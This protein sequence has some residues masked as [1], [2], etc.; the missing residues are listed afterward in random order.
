M[1]LSFR[2]LPIRHKLITLTVG[3]SG[4]ALVLACTVFALF[5]QAGF[6]RTSARDIAI[7][8]D[9]FDDNVAAGVTFDD[10][11]AIA[12]TLQTLRANPHIVAACVYDRQGAVIGE[13]RRSGP[14]A[15][16]QF[17]FPVARPTSQQVTP[18]R[19][20]TF[21]DITLAGEV[22]GVV[23]IG[24]E[25]TELHAR[26]RRYVL[27]VG[28]LLIACSFV[29]WALARWL[30][31]IISQPILELAQ[32]V[33]TIATEKNY[34]VRAPKQGDDELGRLIDGFNEMLT[35]IQARDTALR[36]AGEK[37]E[38]RVEERTKELAVERARFKFIFD[39]VPVGITLVS[40]DFKVHLTNPATERI[41]GVAVADVAQPDAFVR[42]SHPDDYRRQMELAQPFIRGEIDHYSVEKRYVHPNGHIVWAL[43]TSRKFFASATR[44][45]QAVTTLVDIS[46]LKNAQALAAREQAR[47]KFIFDS[48]P[49]GISF[50]VNDGSNTHLVNPAHARI[51]GV[52]AESAG[53]AGVFQRA[54]HP[55]DY[56]RQMEAAQPFIRAEVD[57]YSVE[58]RYLHADGSVVWTA[59]T[60]RKFTDAATGVLQSITTLIDITE[61]KKAETQL[62]NSLSLLHATLESTADGILVVG[63]GG[64]LTTF[65]RTFAEMWCLPP[66]V[67]GRPDSGTALEVVLGQLKQPETFRQRVRDLTAQPETT[68]FDMLDLR[69]GRIF[70]SY[71]QPQR[72][73]PAVAGRVW[74]FRDVTERRKTEDTLRRQQTELRVLFDLVPAMIWFKDTENRILRVNRRVADNAGKS[75][76]EIEGKP[77][78]EIYPHEAAKFYADD[79]KVIRSG[80][81]E[82][83]IVEALHGTKDGEVWVQT[84]KVPVTDGEG[85]VIGIIVMA[86]D[87]TERKRSEA[88]LLKV[89]R[90]LV[91]ASRQAGM[92]EVATGVLH[93]VGN[94][95]NSVNVSA[96]L[97]SD[98]VRQTAAGKIA[99]LATLVQ[100]H[101][102]DLAAFLTT[103]PRGRLI[104]DYLGTLAAAL[105]TEHQATLDELDHL[106]KNI[107]HIKEIVA[108]QQSY[109]RASGIIETVVLAELVDDTLRMNTGSFAQHGIEAIRDYQARP[110]VS[111]D[112]HKVMQI[113]INLVRNAKYAC[114]DSGRPDKRITLHTRSDEQRFTIAVSDNG[115]GISRENLTRIFSHGFTTRPDGH[116]FGLHSGALAARELGGSLSVQS[117]GPGLG[118]T[119]TLELP[120][121]PE[122]PAHDHPAR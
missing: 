88:E 95:L 112:K 62:A 63:Q 57:H 107:D 45:E 121:Q 100:A 14:Q 103:D 116:G 81:S 89:H 10:S 85:R 92:A 46:E 66:E 48:V 56:R 68:S 114:D 36:T 97:I 54:S 77:S 37:L 31:R 18:D 15:D 80:V 23:Y 60:S 119:F 93:N 41:T 104:P 25:L 49:V 28:V 72:V 47:F 61:R 79:L 35:Q 115:V 38:G 108:V 52:S 16:P 118:A 91:A 13:Y 120:C 109:A 40:G 86:Q 117:D 71:S 70:E 76:E 9:M 32:T 83:G 22:I 82:L 29:A 53:V 21:Q 87:I 11:E 51:T 105:A 55:D 78:A 58:K 3:I 102:T 33:A 44:E 30:Q 65:N 90:E 19:L 99:K 113:L 12:R 64:R 106:R 110:T 8:A 27:F 2:N 43:L 84:D 101:Q 59:L 122:P 24:V 4:I 20:D 26:A 98:R 75:V 1:H 73:G 39:S 34:G 96:T 5:E 17:Q 50:V 69:D 42:A 6:R 7:L 74:C 67:L 111:T 94:V